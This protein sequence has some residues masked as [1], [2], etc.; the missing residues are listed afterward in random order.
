MD[1]RDERKGS[2]VAKKSVQEKLIDF[3][4]DAHAMEQ[5]V[6]GMLDSMIAATRDEETARELEQHKLETERHEQRLRERLRAHGRGTSMRKEA[7]SIGAALMKG[8]A[9][10]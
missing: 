2:S 6:L 7:Q 1:E 9:D 8:V 4:E 10:Q 3:I 5:N